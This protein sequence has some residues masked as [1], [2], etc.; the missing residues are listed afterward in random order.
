M[1]GLLY[2]PPFVSLPLSATQEA[3]D[4]YLINRVNN[5]LA[6]S[7]YFVSPLFGGFAQRLPPLGKAV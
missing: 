3:L 5:F 1:T 4:N 7:A 2:R 6:L